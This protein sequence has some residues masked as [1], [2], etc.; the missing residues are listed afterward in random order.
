M[1]IKEFIQSVEVVVPLASVGYARDT[2]GLQVG[3]ETA[4]LRKVLIAYEVTSEVLNE[5]IETGANLI[6]A[7]HPLIFPNIDRLTNASRTGKLVRDL[8]KNDLS[9]YVLHTAFDSHL[10]F[11][12][13]RLMAEALQLRSVRSLDPLKATLNKIVVF[14]P[15]NSADEVRKALQDSGA[16]ALGNYDACTWQ[17]EGRGTFRGN[18]RSNPAIGKKNIL[19]TVEEIRIEAICESWKT[20]R[21]IQAMCDVHPYES[22]ACDIYALENENPNFGMG[23]IGEWAE[24]INVNEALERVRAA[25]G[26]P[27]LRHNAVSEKRV[28]RVAMLGGAGMEFYSAAL[29]SKADMFITADIRYHDFYRASHD[30]MLLV[31]AGH[32]ETERFV[33][34]GMLRAIRKALATNQSGDPQSGLPLVVSHAEPNAVHYF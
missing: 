11:G 24:A 3:D 32:S 20:S 5:A 25:F 26:T 1:L 31:D 10:E 22:V 18:D 4:E 12:T 21:A 23:A 13:S 6:V 14:V 28:K 8:M 15:I 29:R 19:E 9:L 2:V 33:A 34:Q 16:G 17:V 27:M 7:F 30:N